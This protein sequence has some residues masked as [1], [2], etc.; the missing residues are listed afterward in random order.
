MKREA[1]LM[2][3]AVVTA[4]PGGV[5]AKGAGKPERES[6]PCSG[7]WGSTQTMRLEAW[8]ADEVATPKAAALLSYIKQVLAGARYR[9]NALQEF[10]PKGWK[11][12]L[13]TEQGRDV[14]LCSL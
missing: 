11:V 14:P 9:A 3:M 13:R 12:E 1:L 8:G 10:E 5:H 2:G 4:L 6:H 7:I